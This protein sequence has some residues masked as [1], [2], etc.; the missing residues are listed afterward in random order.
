MFFLPPAERDVLIDVRFGAR[1]EKSLRIDQ[2]P[3]PHA[4]PRRRRDIAEDGPR[5]HQDR[6]VGAAQRLG[7]GIDPRRDPRKFRCVGVD[8]RVVRDDLG[9]I[10]GQAMRESHGG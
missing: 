5:R 7:N 2:S 10:C 8:G 4:G 1:L 3:V 6:R 9:T